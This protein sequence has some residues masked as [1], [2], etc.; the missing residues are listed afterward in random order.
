MNYEKI[1]SGISTSL[2]AAISHCISYMDLIYPLVP[3]LH[4]SLNKSKT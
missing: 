4:M 1:L 3:V 2:Y